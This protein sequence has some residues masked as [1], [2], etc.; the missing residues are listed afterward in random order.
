[1][2]EI[3]EL[4]KKTAVSAEKKT[5]L[6][7]QSGQ[8]TI[9]ELLLL[10]N[11]SPDFYKFFDDMSALLSR[12][13][14]LGE[15]LGLLIN[16]ETMSGNR[17][18]SKNLPDKTKYELAEACRN[19]V[20]YENALIIP[21]NIKN[22][23]AF[24][25]MLPAGKSRKFTK[26]EKALI[27]A[28]AAITT[29]RIESCRKDISIAAAKEATASLAQ[30]E[31]FFSSFPDL[32]FDLC[33]RTVL[34]EI[35]KVAKCEA[36]YACLTDSSGKITSE[37]ISAASK[38][39]GDQLREEAKR[40][41]PQI[42]DN[43]MPYIG[44]LSCR[45]SG[46]SSVLS[47]DKINRYTAVPVLYAGHANG[48]I[49]ATNSNISYSLELPHILSRMARLY[50]MLTAIKKDSRQ[51]AMKQA[52]H[53]SILEGSWDM[54]FVLNEK[55]DITYVSPSVQK[56]LGY[57]VSEVEGHNFREFVPEEDLEQLTSKLNITFKTG[58]LIPTNICRV[59]TKDGRE[60]LTQLRM[61]VNKIEGM[62]L[63]ISAIIR[64]ITGDIENQK[65]L[66]EKNLF[67]KAIFSKSP[68]AIFIANPE[69][70]TI[71]RANN[72][73]AKFFGIPLSELAGYDIISLHPEGD[74]PEMLELLETNRNKAKSSSKTEFSLKKR[75]RMLGAG[76]EITD[77]SLTLTYLNIQH[78]DMVLLVIIENLSAEKK[79]IEETA[80]R[81]ALLNNS[82]DF[83]FAID[84]NSSAIVFANKAMCTLTGINE[85]DIAA[86]FPLLKIYPSKQVA[87]HRL[88]QLRSKMKTHTVQ[89][90]M[91][92]DGSEMQVESFSAKTL[93]NG[94]PV[95]IIASRD[96]GEKL[97]LEKELYKTNETLSSL[98]SSLPDQ[99]QILNSENTITYDNH[100]ENAVYNSKAADG[101]KEHIYNQNISYKHGKYLEQVLK[102]GKPVS[103]MEE[104][105]GKDGSQLYLE[106]R[107]VPIHD[108][109]GNISGTGIITRDYTSKKQDIE[110]ITSLEFILK[111]IF[112]TSQDFIY[113]ID[114]E[115]RFLMVNQAAAVYYG[116][117]AD[118]M[119]GKTWRELGLTAQS[120]PR[121]VIRKIFETKKKAFFTREYVF[122][123]RK[124][125]ES[126]SC[127][128]VLNADG[129]VT[130]VVVAGRDLTKA[131]EETTDKA[132]N[133]AKEIVSM[134][135]RPI[136]HDFNN[137]LTVINGYATLL[138][139]TSKDDTRITAGLRQIIKAVDR[140]TRLTER[141]QTFARNPVLTGDAGSG[142][143]LKHG[144]ENSG[145]G[146]TKQ[147]K[148]KSEKKA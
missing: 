107:I 51:L 39:T 9:F 118:E 115:G 80:F 30:L 38:Q 4:N 75:T 134:K 60:L 131:H 48:L 72:N 114:L 27:Q 5:K 7:K 95:A 57:A 62:P 68:Q 53:S 35:V 66:H 98:F 110:K 83:L 20:A 87:Q 84:L 93:F 15:G 47:S 135:M 14:V 147:I 78:G 99:V 102:T 108:A 86:G 119:K 11:T 144:N 106:K 137:I 58:K 128:P 74:R 64:D 133:A 18:V 65:Q 130:S 92:G 85:K 50:S 42:K 73:A 89:T 90:I 54:I 1:M 103:F 12:E 146:P 136:G 43:A 129:D 141:F 55:G 33:A 71:L 127:S 124:F 6:K 40:I 113:V 100:A 59:I 111:H 19:G 13:D 123:N 142:M 101:A 143:P 82:P 79:H 81:A 63:S 91:R 67:Y 120:T 61:T 24:M 29:N 49:I 46:D 121:K 88:E 112:E 52:E 77:V 132:I 44:E 17:S 10:L 16:V 25:A 36:V 122:R 117:N 22:A 32:P 140:A 45:L 28:A 31:T 26:D 96:I 138:S 37:S 109:D 23:S 34:D 126:L 70:Y 76:G 56:L 21:L 148:E 139:E 116:K 97:T 41:L 145:S 2:K 69:T 104:A 94:K 3:S 8:K 125:Y 105:A